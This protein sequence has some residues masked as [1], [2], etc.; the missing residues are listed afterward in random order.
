MDS[1]VTQSA[2]QRRLNEFLTTLGIRLAQDTQIE[3]GKNFVRSTDFQSV[4]KDAWIS[5]GLSANQGF[6][7]A[8]TDYVFWCPNGL[9]SGKSICVASS[10]LSQNLDQHPDW[11]DAFRTLVCRLDATEQ[12]LLTAEKTTAERFV[13]RA[14]Q[15]FDL[16]ILELRPCPRQLNANWFQQEST[17][18]TPDVFPAYVLPLEPKP[19]IGW[20]ELLISI[21]HEVRVL[22]VRKAGNVHQAIQARCKNESP[23]VF[24]LDSTSL[25][26]PKLQ[27]E[28][29]DSGCVRW[30]V[31]Q[32]SAAPNSSSTK[33]FRIPLTDTLPRGEFLIHCTRPRV[34]AWPDQAETQFLDDLIFQE[35][36]ADHSASAALS[37]IMATGFILGTNQL[38]R[39]SRKVVCFTSASLDQLSSLTK[40]QSHLGRWDFLPV[41][42]AIRKSALEDIGAK[43]V[44]YGDETTWGLMPETAR[45]FFQVEE[46]ITKK[47]T[48]IDWRREM[49]WRYLGDLDLNQFKT[50]DIFAFESSER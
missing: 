24:L 35:T 22:S 8:D 18:T 20:D 25:T 9:P 13:Q 3:P 42:I 21:A 32:Q 17:Q 41:G 26:A 14:G 23:N 5:W 34:G 4:C 16:N 36:R 15:L 43:P 28:L 11:F 50:G 46:T 10:R 33:Q 7:D 30:K 6:A 45:P 40:F 37:R 49:E 47:G 12:F 44:I 39:D 27:K 1:S 31:L 38:T 19:K 2:I 48:M 29:W